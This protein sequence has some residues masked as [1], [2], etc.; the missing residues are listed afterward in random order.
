MREK[1]EESAMDP[2]ERYLQNEKLAYSVLHQAFPQYKFDE[3]FQ[4]IA[5]I[6][7][8]KACIT[9]DEEKAAFTTYAYRCC[10]NEIL[11]ELRKKK[12]NVPSISMDDV[13]IHNLKI[14]DALPCTCDVFGAVSMGESMRK[15]PEKKKRI[16]W[17]LVRGDT[18]NEIGKA[19]GITQASVSRC[20]KSIQRELTEAI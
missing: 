1:Q 9:F 3:D 6:G 16:L 5:K 19:L 13:L 15:M 14:E 11:P 2:Q 18:Q 20:I 7:L 8:W 12:K 10:I 4:Q 17:M